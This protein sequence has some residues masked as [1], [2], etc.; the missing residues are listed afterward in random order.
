MVL[1]LS[2]FAVSISLVVWRPKSL[3][4]NEATAAALGAAVMVLIGIISPQQAWNVLQA[5]A[6]VLLFFLG[7]MIISS[8]ADQAGFFAWCAFKS[9]RLAHGRGSTLLIIIFGLGAALTAFFPTMLR[10]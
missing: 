5:N 9:A 4:L 10:H 3:H 7:L 2:I 8:I 1:T 6:N